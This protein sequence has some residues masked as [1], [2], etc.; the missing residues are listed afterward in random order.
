MFSELMPLIQHRPLTLTIAAVDDKQIRVNVIPGKIEKDRAV[1]KEIGHS[2]SKEVAPI[3]ESAILALT[4]PLSL[5]GTPDEID[6]QLAKTLTEFTVLH[7]G[8]QNSFDAAAGAIAK[9]VKEIDDRERIKKE[10]DKAKNKKTEPAK[11]EEKKQ[12][13]DAFPSLFSAPAAQTA[14]SANDSTTAGGGV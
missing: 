13:P 4:T 8:L 10:Q 11:I 2:H 6:A 12:E 5:T 1:N 9:A 3:P 7:V 14:V